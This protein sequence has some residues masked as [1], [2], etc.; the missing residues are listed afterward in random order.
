MADGDSAA[1]S[2]KLTGLPASGDEKGLPRRG[3]VSTFRSNFWFEIWETV[4]I[5]EQ[6]M[7]NR[8]SC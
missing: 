2:G 6:G 5:R 7:G 1:A 8:I 3:K 4:R